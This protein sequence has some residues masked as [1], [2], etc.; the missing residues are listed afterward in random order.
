MLW[1][2]FR[3]V[4]SLSQEMLYWGIFSCVFTENVCVKKK[5]TDS[6]GCKHFG[7]SLKLV[8][9]LYLCL[10]KNHGASCLGRFLFNQL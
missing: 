8:V 9:S 4:I 1:L 2:L 7:S 10:D 3:A 6:D 5:N